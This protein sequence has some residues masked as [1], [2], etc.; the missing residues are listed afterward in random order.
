MLPRQLQLPEVLGAGHFDD[1]GAQC[2][3]QTNADAGHEQQRGSLWVGCGGKDK[4]GPRKSCQSSPIQSPTE[5]DV[6]PNWQLKQNAIARRDLGDHPHLTD[7]V[8]SLVK[9][10]K[11]FEHI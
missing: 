6:C 2:E 11:V 9:E 8:L 7:P 1:Q 5:A 4:S 3:C 10:K